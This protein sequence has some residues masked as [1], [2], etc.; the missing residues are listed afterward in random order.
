MI[1]EKELRDFDA[2]YC[3]PDNFY[4]GKAGLGDEKA[5]EHFTLTSCWSS[6]KMKLSAQSSWSLGE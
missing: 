2:Y 6:Q 5:F 3:F 4:G 1:Y